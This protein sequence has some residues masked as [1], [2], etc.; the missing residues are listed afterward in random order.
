M[1]KS[2]TFLLF[3]SCCGL[4]GF[5]VWQFFIHQQ[6]KIHPRSCH[7]K[8]FNENT[9]SFGSGC[10]GGIDGHRD[11]GWNPLY[12]PTSKEAAVDNLTKRLSTQNPEDDIGICQNWLDL[13]ITK[14]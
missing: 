6:L 3:L 8:T 5:F 14:E 13:L 9:C 4:V 11:T 2:N 12:V 7:G 1:N 10:L